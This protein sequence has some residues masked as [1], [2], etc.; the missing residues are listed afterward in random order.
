LVG[1]LV[2]PEYDPDKIANCSTSLPGFDASWF[3]VHRFGHGRLDGMSR[4]LAAIGIE[5]QRPP[6]SS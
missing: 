4:K 2:E 1:W 6:R 3:D 5:H